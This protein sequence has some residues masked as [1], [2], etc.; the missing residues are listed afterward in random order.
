MSFLVFSGNQSKENE[1]S[2]LKIVEKATGHPFHS[3]EIMSIPDDKE[4]GNSGECDRLHSDGTQDKKQ[5]TKKKLNKYEQ[6]FNKKER[7][8]DEQ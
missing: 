3:Q 2:E 6:T 5:H 8:A 7:M 1:N 4:K